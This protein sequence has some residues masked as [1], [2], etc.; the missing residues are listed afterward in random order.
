VPEANH[1]V[2]CVSCIKAKQAHPVERRIPVRCVRRPAWRETD[3]PLPLRG[4]AHQMAIIHTLFWAVGGTA[5]QI[6]H[7]ITVIDKYAAQAS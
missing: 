4:F 5:Q 6:I 2:C 3:S 1:D 7:I